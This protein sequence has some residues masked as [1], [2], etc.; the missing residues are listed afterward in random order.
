MLAPEF[1]CCKLLVYKPVILFLNWL[2]CS[3][4]RLYK[5]KWS[6]LETRTNG[7]KTGQMGLANCMEA[8]QACWTARKVAEQFTEAYKQ[9]SL[10]KQNWSTPAWITFS[11]APVYPMK[12]VHASIGWVWF[13]RL[14]SEAKTNMPKK[15]T[16]FFYFNSK[17]GREHLLK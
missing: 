14:T 10:A 3:Y 6:Y 2:A 13:A 15:L 9:G 5:A 16:I 12:L 4:F 17:V 1:I 7:L 11:V 8:V